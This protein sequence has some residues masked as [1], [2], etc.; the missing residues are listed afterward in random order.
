MA[1]DA[2]RGSKQNKKATRAL[3]T[4][5]HGNAGR[6]TPLSFSTWDGGLPVA[7][8]CKQHYSPSLVEMLR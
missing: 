1:M 2:F 8:S 6:T 7:S 4:A 3:R 5:R